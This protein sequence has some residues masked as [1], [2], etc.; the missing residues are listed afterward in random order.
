MRTP[1]YPRMSPS[2]PP[3]T[4]LPRSG[5]N[6]RSV[7][8]ISVNNTARAS[9]ANIPSS[10]VLM[11]RSCSCQTRLAANIPRR[12]APASDNVPLPLSANPINTAVSPQDTMARQV[13]T[14]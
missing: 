3:A 14:G 7:I 13:K 5:R 6:G 11:E 4:R 9:W 10:L 2:P 1:M 12:S 8:S